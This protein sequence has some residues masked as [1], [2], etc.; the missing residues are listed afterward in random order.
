[1]MPRGGNQKDLMKQAQQ[2][3]AKLMKAQEELEQSVVEGT[4]G[5]GVV[6]VTMSGQF[7]VQNVVIDPDAVS[8]DDVEMLQDLVT[9]AVNEA[10]EKVQ[11]LQSQSMGALTGGLKIPG[12]M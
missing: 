12:L 2:L 9:A 7:R 4:A 5:G 3:Q 11:S 8:P 6:T 1:M 10:I